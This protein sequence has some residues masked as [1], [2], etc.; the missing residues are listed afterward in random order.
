MWQILLTY[1][2]VHFCLPLAASN[3]VSQREQPIQNY[4]RKKDIT[5]IN[6]IRGIGNF[7]IEKFNI[8]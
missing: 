1:D 6:L 4:C 8:K 3:G 7:S 2:L 5:T